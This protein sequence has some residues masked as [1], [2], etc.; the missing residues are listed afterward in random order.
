MS[1]MTGLEVWLIGTPTELDTALA[2]LRTAGRITGA[3][4]PEP[5]YG[6]DTGRTRRYLRVL[7]PIQARATTPPADTGQAVIDLAAH[8]RRRT[9]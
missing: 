2:A 9:A 7:V 4:I 8:R 1:A 6:T 5:L 3:S